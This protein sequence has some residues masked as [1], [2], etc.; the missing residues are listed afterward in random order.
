[1]HEHLQTP[2][3]QL[4]ILLRACLVLQGAEGVLSI[5][6]EVAQ[7]LVVSVEKSFSLLYKPENRRHIPAS[8]TKGSQ[9][10]C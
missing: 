1:M 2:H 10:L 6:V 3:R 4:T 9:N 5:L 8:S 7:A